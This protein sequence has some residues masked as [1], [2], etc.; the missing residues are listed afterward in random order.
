MS[1]K[2]IY[3]LSYLTNEQIRL[4][5]NIEDNE[6]ECLPDDLIDISENMEIIKQ[7]YINLYYYMKHTSGEINT[8]E[9]EKSRLNDI[10][11]A[12]K[13]VI[14]KIKTFM[15]SNLKVLHENNLLEDKA[16]LK[17]DIVTISIVEKKGYKCEIDK[18]KYDEI[19]NNLEDE[20]VKTKVEKTIKLDE[21]SKAFAEKKIEKIDGINFKP[22][23]YLMFK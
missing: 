15:L 4:L 10:I 8:L 20:Y 16:K 1:L 7:K 3:D 21:L 17:T 19:C 18:I 23:E 12:K 11:N 6:G 13:N 2:T 14:D 9:T 22:I 5:E